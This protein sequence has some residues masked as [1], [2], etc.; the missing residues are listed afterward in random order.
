MGR[1]FF[2]A[3]ARTPADD[4]R[5]ALSE[6]ERLMA[7]L[8]KAGPQEVELLS[9]FDEIANGLQEL[10]A[11]GMDARVERSRFE[12]VQLQLDRNKGRFLT[13]VG[14]AF[15]EAREAAQPDRE[16]P[17]WFIDEEWAQERRQKL[18]RVLTIGAIMVGVLIVLGIPYQIFLAPS[19]EE[20]AVLRSESRGE[21]L[22]RED[23]DFAAALVEF[24][25]ASALFPDDPSHWVWIGVL[26]LELGDEEG[27]EKALV[28]ARS[29]YP[30][31]ADF[32][33]KRAQVYRDVGDLDAALAD[34]DQAILEDPDFAWAY[35]TRHFIYVER[36]DIRSALDDLDKAEELAQESK[37]VQLQAVVRYQRAMVLQMPPASPSPTP[38]PTQ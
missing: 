10:E 16:Q 38:T 20:R 36:G 27:S 29:L 7:N 23:K 17:W 22:V 3:E 8:R 19:P 14:K 13:K 12:T 1:H 32:L 30:R 35:Y 33:L 2:S 26:R 28:T 18:R 31:N 24:E 5:E 11:A 4:V 37:D 25:A 34:A 9:L 6:A 21:Y 15:G